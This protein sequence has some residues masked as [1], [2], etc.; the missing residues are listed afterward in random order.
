ML[1]RNVFIKI[2][3][4]SVLIVLLGLIRMFESQLFYDPFIAYYK[5][6]FIALPY[7]EVHDVKLILNLCFRYLL[8][9][10]ITLGVIY[11]LFN[12]KS[13]IKLSA[14]LLAVFMIVLMMGFVGLFYLFDSEYA[15]TL[16]YVR[17]FLIQPIFLLLF[18]PAF[19]YQ[20]LSIGDDL[21][22]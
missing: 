15:M 1:S 4:L 2:V 22:K 18:V 5:N 16:F 9:S 14:V 7:P 13:M 6:E 3:Q 20:K 8:N 21:E 11:V 19:Y 17:R 10:V 12:N